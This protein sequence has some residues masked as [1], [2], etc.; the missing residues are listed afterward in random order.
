MSKVLLMG[1]ISLI[2][3]LGALQLIGWMLTALD[4]LRAGRLHLPPADFRYATRGVWVFLA[5]LIYGLATAVVLYGAF[6]VVFFT[7]VAM[8]PHGNTDGSTSVVFPLAFFSIMFG[9]LGLIT[10]LSLVLFIFVPV[11]VLSIDR[12]GFEG[13]FRFGDFINA[14]RLSSRETLIAGG[15]TF[16]S[17][18]ISGMG[19]YLC[20]VGVLFTIPYSMAMLAGVLR[21]YEVNAMPG[22]VPTPVTA[23]TATVST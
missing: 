11:L 10:A 6:F 2:P 20:Y 14:F 4:N 1:L 7:T 23:G 19:T 8:T 3:F 13:A 17:Y 21:W 22:A 9:S 12:Y 15:L 18:F 5:G 16:V